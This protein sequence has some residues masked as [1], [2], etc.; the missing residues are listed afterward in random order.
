LL[1]IIS[2]KRF[3]DGINKK[4]KR[5]RDTLE[6]KGFKL[7]RSKYLKCKFS[8]EESGIKHKVYIGSVAIPRVEKFIY[9]G[10]IIQ[11]NENT[12]KD[13]NHLIKVRWQK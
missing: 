8:E 2:P 4:L 3:K 7:S 9:L 6:T 13:V 10:S 11:E 12:D 5:W 1:W